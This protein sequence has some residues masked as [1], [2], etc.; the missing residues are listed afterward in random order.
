MALSIHPSRPVLVTS[1]IFAARML[2]VGTMPTPGAT[3]R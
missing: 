1:Q 3:P 2:P